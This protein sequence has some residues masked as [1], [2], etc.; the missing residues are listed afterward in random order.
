MYVLVAVGVMTPTMW[1]PSGV[2][3]RVPLKVRTGRVRVVGGRGAGALGN[4]GTETD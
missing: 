1:E 4:A 2:R 3:I